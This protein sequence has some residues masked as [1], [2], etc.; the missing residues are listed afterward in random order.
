M[1]MKQKRSAFVTWTLL[2]SLLGAVSAGAQEEGNTAPETTLPP[3]VVQDRQEKLP[4]LVDVT[5]AQIYAGKPVTITNLRDQPAKVS[6]EFRQTFSRTPGV[7]VSE[8]G[9]PSVV[10]LTIRGIGEPHESQ[11]VLIF[12]DGIPIQSTLFGYPTLYYVPANE[13]LQSVE[14]FKGGSSLLYGPQPAGAINFITVDP[15]EGKPFEATTTNLFGSHGMMS[16]FAQVS[17]TSG[18]AGYLASFS[19]RSADGFRSTNSGY[20]IFNGNIKLFYDLSEDTRI[21]L[22][23][24]AYDEETEEA[25]R[26]SFAQWQADDTQVLPGNR[27]DKL[28]LRK[29]FGALTIDHR[30]SDSLKVVSKTY[31]HYQ[32]RM[33]RRDNGALTLTDLDDR[34][35]RS[36]GND[37]RF[38]YETDLFDGEVASTTT[39]G[40]TVYYANDPNRRNR[41]VGGTTTATSGLPALQHQ[42]RETMYGAIFAENIFEY[43]NFR[44]IPSGRLDLVKMDV[45][46]TLGNAGVNTEQLDVVPLF[47]MAFEYDLP[48]NQTAYFS[49]AQGYQPPQYDQLQRRG[50]AAPNPESE[51]GSTFTYELGVKGEPTS[52]LTYDASLFHVDYQDFIDVNEDGNDNVLLLNAGDIEFWGID[53]AFDLNATNLYD[54]LNDTSYEERFGALGLFFAAEFLETSIVSGPFNG[55]EASYAPPYSIK[56]GPTYRHSSGFK[57]ELTATYIGETF[58]NTRNA[59]SF[60]P[61]GNNV[62]TSKIQSYAVWDFAMEAPVYRDHV[63][64]LFG[65]NNLFDE[66][67]YSRVRA[68]GIQPV[69]GRTFYAGFNATF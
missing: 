50:A 3:V 38:L 55:N 42:S 31:A 51:P 36:I 32:Q 52:W 33:T 45:H 14:V 13:T 20:S 1:K 16:N 23:Y 60:T 48:Q 27:Q 39:A 17:G 69:A 63:K 30:F 58:W 61:G 18:N 68:D 53:V 44:A 59:N 41:F 35:F 40:Y 8:T 34:L 26:L 2:T 7:Y 54:S 43:G 4:P 11:D 6:G 46:N 29:H 37:T 65:I 49:F 28:F 56:F 67:Y 9:D 21:S 66:K 25:G 57:A 47:G 5:E 62:G 12:Q 64:L 24:T 10:N 19:H 15:A 22:A